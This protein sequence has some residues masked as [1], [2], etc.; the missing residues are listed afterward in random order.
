[1]HAHQMIV[2]FE[3]GEAEQVERRKDGLVVATMDWDLVQKIRVF[4]V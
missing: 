1:M 2:I 3:T 4:N